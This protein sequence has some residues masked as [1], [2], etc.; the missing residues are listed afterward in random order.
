LCCIPQQNVLK[1]NVKLV[2]E[3]VR[4]FTEAK[5]LKGRMA[6]WMNMSAFI[7]ILAFAEMF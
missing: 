4:S 5:V 6:L 3:Q 2:K 7:F 1:E